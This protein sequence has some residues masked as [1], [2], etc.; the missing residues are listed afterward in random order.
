MAG[1]LFGGVEVEGVGGGGGEGGGRNTVGRR[2]L[3]CFIL[4][5]EINTSIN[6]FLS[7]AG[8]Y[9]RG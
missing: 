2:T 4:Y 6:I 1:A 8:P 7:E 5:A 9:A 3:I